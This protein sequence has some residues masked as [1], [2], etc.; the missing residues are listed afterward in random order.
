MAIAGHS[1][2]VVQGMNCLRSLGRWNRGFV[3]RSGHGYLVCVCFFFCVC[4]VLCLGRGLATSWSLVQGVLPSLKV[5]MKLKEEV[6][7]LGGC[8]ASERQNGDL[9]TRYPFIKLRSHI[10]PFTVV[11][12]PFDSDR[13]IWR[14]NDA[15]GSVKPWSCVLSSVHT[16]CPLAKTVT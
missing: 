2:R 4:V 14:V 5:I 8:R 3:S 13:Q 9:P 15:G 16:G 7:S 12:S 11:W 6:R 10:R 1:S